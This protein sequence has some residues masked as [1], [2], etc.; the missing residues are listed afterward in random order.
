M[1]AQGEPF[2]IWLHGYLKRARRFL[3]RRKQ[4]AVA[5]G[6]QHFLF[7]ILKWFLEEEEEEEEWIRLERMRVNQTS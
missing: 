4:D 3:T 1:R 2:F 5:L 6:V 7:R